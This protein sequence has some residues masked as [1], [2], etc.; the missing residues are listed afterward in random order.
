[1]LTEVLVAGSGANYLIAV[2]GKRLG[3]CGILWF[4]NALRSQDFLNY[5][6]EMNS[7][8]I[9]SRAQQLFAISSGGRSIGGKVVYDPS[10][11]PIEHF[12]SNCNN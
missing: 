10:S 2:L 7:F 8:A 4:G 5:S 11:N 6:F 1:M 12:P 3:F 9:L